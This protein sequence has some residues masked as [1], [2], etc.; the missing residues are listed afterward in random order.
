MNLLA[1]LPARLL[2]IEVPRS[3]E[4][5]PTQDPAV[6]LCLGPYGGTRGWAFAYEP[7]TPVRASKDDWWW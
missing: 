4:D 2:C 6:G 1:P 5:A 3:E 7:G